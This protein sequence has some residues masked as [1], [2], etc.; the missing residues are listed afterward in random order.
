[1]KLSSRAFFILKSKEICF[2]IILAPI[3]AATKG[4]LYPKV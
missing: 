1:M 4:T 3:D 2:P